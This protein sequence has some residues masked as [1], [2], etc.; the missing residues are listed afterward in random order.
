MRLLFVSN[1]FPPEVNA[2]ATRLVEHARQW[3]A[4]G[5]AVEVLTSNPNFPEGEIYAGY[6]N[7]FGHGVVDGIKVTR[8]PMYV[9]ENKGTLKRTLSYL[10]FGLSALLRS[11]QLQQKPDLVVAT[12]PQFF[13]ALGGYALA[14]VHRVPFV[15]EVRDLWPESIVAVGA[16]QRGRVIEA[17]EALER[18]L[19]RH[20][21][22]I[23]VVT[24][25][26]KE[27]I[28]AKG[29][30]GDKISVVKNGA[31]L[32]FYGTPLDPD[33]LAEL[34]KEFG[35]EGKFVAA[36][37]GTLGMAH[38]ADVLLEAAQ[39]C[40]DPDVL[41]VVMGAGAERAAL[42]AKQRALG[43]PNFRLLDKQPKHLMP[44]LLALSDV[45]VVHLRDMP[46]FGTVIPSKIF[47]AMAMGRPVVIGVRGESQKIV[48][49]G[50]VG[51]A[52]PPEDPEALVE[53]V[54]RL[55]S[56]PELYARLSTNGPAYVRQ[57]YDR[58]TL[59]RRYW[60]VLAEV[61]QRSRPPRRPAPPASS[62]SDR[63]LS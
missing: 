22:H 17:F 48:E 2:P 34:R 31:D 54:V 35:F 55:K 10:S 18:Y 59:A 37:M 44:Y 15:L 29:I 53:A 32:T 46:L 27:A 11:G 21:D 63:S 1:Y 58:K 36:Y 7:R 30:A 26:F 49:D 20:A 51:L 50:D 41:F 43:L 16:V 6:T 60:D 9:A 57:H 3:T 45:N 25:A 12:S 62:P 5:H 38:R 23:V 56:S 33:R 19:Y 13:C 40:P 39:R 47:E 24:D 28:M 52:I 61:W 42:E 4:D 14:R 8:V